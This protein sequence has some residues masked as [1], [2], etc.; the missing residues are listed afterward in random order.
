[1]KVIAVVITSSPGPMSSAFSAMWRAA[2]PELQAMLLG[3]LQA[4]M[5]QLLTVLSAV[6][7]D[8]MMVLKEVEKKKQ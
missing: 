5:R 8:L 6:P 2:V 7:R 1:M 4:P 3:V